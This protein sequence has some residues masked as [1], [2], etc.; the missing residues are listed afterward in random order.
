[1]RDPAELVIATVFLLLSPSQS[2]SYHIKSITFA[3]IWRA[4]T[5]HDL[6]VAP[7]I[8]QMPMRMH[9]EYTSYLELCEYDR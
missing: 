3:K 7:T 6:A 9:R 2:H 5:C 4:A 8:M 1:M